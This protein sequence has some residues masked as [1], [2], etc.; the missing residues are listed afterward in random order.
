[1]NFSPI[2]IINFSPAAIAKT[3]TKPVSNTISGTNLAPLK[4]DTVSFSGKPEINIKLKEAIHREDYEEVLQELGYDAEKDPDT[5]KLY[6]SEYSQPDEDTT[7]EDYGINEQ[8]LFN[9]IKQFEGETYMQN[10]SVVKLGD[11]NFEFLNIEDS[12][13]KDLGHAKINVL[14]LNPEQVKDLNFKNAQIND[15]YIVEKDETGDKIGKLINQ[16]NGELYYFPD[17]EK[18]YKLEQTEI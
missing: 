10:S 7:F 15:L 6:V 11:Q 17:A 3:N 2:S 8:R 9:S 5:G 14:V 4:Q 1:M 18:I 12:K 16:I 13:V